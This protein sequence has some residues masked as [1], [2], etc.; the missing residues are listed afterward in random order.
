MRWIAF[1]TMETDQYYS[2]WCAYDTLNSVSTTTD[3][4]YS[5]TSGVLHAAKDT[6]HAE[7]DRNQP[8]LTRRYTMSFF[9]GSS[10]RDIV[11]MRGS[12][13]Y[14]WSELRCMEAV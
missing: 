7:T 10:A 6:G 2:S 3:E 1:D 12:S 14:V 11:E 4:K 9:F 5:M 13:V 8:S